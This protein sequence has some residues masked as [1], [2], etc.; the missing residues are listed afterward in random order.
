MLLT[1][2]YFERN[3]VAMP[4]TSNLA[5]AVYFTIKMMTALSEITFVTLVAQTGFNEDSY[6]VSKTIKINIIF[7]CTIIMT[8]VR[9]TYY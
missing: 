8:F 4:S 7:I 3:L 6:T 1:H 2:R 9:D 5:A